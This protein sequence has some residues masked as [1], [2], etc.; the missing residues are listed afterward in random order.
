MRLV[1]VLLAL[2][3]QA[4]IFVGVDKKSNSL[5]DEEILPRSILEEYVVVI[6]DANYPH[7]KMALKDKR[8]K[9]PEL[10]NESK[11]P[12]PTNPVRFSRISKRPDLRLLQKTT[13]RLRTA[14]RHVW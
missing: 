5:P 9:N 2:T 6:D 8:D 11:R 4:I 12:T 1:V 10:K 13:R 14:R 7:G 3:F